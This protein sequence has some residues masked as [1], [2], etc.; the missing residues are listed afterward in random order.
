MFKNSY[1]LHNMTT[2]KCCSDLRDFSTYCI[3]KTKQEKSFG[4]IDILIICDINIIFMQGGLSYKG[5]ICIVL[6]TAL[7]VTALVM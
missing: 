6:L 1:S 3:P 2:N 7:A 4:D 5:A